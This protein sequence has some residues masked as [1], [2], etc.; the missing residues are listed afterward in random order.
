[1][2]RILYSNFQREKESEKEGKR[3]PVSL[4]ILWIAILILQNNAYDSAEMQM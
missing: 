1:M 4:R 3:H 2:G